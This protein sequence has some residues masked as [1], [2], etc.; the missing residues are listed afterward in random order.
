MHL[1]IAI[2]VAEHTIGETQTNVARIDDAVAVPIGYGEI[3]QAGELVI[4][5]GKLDAEAAKPCG[6]SARVVPDH[7]AVAIRVV[8]FEKE[9]EVIDEPVPVDI[10][11]ADCSKTCTFSGVCGSQSS[12]AISIGCSNRSRQHVKASI[13]RCGEIA[14]V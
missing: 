6:R 2:E 3:N 5:S 9:I 7:T 8:L 11:E 4:D 14:E 10:T 13:K 12:I 1:R